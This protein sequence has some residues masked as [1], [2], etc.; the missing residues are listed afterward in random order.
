MFLLGST[1][2]FL[3]IPTLINLLEKVK[4]HPLLREVQNYLL[5]VSPP[6]AKLTKFKIYP[7]Y[8]H[9][10]KDGKKKIDIPSEV[11]SY[12]L[13]GSPSATITMFSHGEVLELQNALL[14]AAFAPKMMGELQKLLEHEKLSCETIRSH[15]EQELVTEE[16]SQIRKVWKDIS[17]HIKQG[18]KKI[19]DIF[20]MLDLIESSLK[21][22]PALR[23]DRIHA[24]FSGLRAEAYNVTK[25][26]L[27]CMKVK[28]EEGVWIHELDIASQSSL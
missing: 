13:D 22:L 11:K 14:N 6:H 24:C 19:D 17:E 26:I 9:S 15:D 28:C 5:D 27:D 12:L 20:S 10:E 8:L 21:V 16:T 1:T 2:E 4:N 18:N 7:E 3:T 25:L 23:K